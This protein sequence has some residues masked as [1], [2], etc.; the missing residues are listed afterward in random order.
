MLLKHLENDEFAVL[1]CG[2]SILKNKIEKN[3]KAILD[4]YKLSRSDI[5]GLSLHY[6][7][8]HKLT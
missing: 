3:T 1:D 6:S 7:Y 8:V 2:V 4:N 5:Q